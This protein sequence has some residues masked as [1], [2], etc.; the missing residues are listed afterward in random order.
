MNFPFNQKLKGGLLI[1]EFSKDI[2]PSEL[3]WHRDRCDR[4]VFV[5]EGSGW[6]LQIDNKLPVLMEEGSYYHIPK[7]TY[8]RMLFEPKF[9]FGEF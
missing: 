4:R 1:R 3:V 7:N 6:L 5:N 2:D 9:E 8:H